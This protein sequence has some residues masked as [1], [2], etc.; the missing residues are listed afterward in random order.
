[1]SLIGSTVIAEEG[2]VT[3]GEQICGIRDEFCIATHSLLIPSSS[4]VSFDPSLKM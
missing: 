4:T 2:T 3:V 1:M